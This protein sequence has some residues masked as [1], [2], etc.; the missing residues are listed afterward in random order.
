MNDLT[1]PQ[2]IVCGYYD[3]SKFGNL[4]I[5]P[6]RIS[7]CYEIEYYLEDGKYVYI[8]GSELKIIADHILIARPG[9]RR[10]SRLPF[11]T[12]FLKF[13]A[14]G[15][16]AEL[17]DR[18]P[19]YFEVLHK[20]QILELLNEIILMTGKFFTL[21]S[22]IVMDG[23][24]KKRGTNYNYSSMYSAKKYIEKNFKKH[25]STKEIAASINL[26]ESRFRYLFGVAYGVSPHAYITE[27]RIS[28]AK[29]MLWNNDIPI[30]E[31]VEKCGFG[32]QQYL[33]DTFK[34]AT[35]VSPGKYRK[36][37]SKKYME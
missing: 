13:E 20:K 15:E 7:E 18:Q 2:K 9:N 27:M 10:R 12:A 19:F 28:A 35:G 17:L 24:H 33:N 23:E 26:S 5:S 21:M 8:N 4:K 14:V 29:K 36:Q 32:S 16:L 37:F 31:I 6:E 1:L 22:F 11:K 30:S 25:I 34:K 3:C